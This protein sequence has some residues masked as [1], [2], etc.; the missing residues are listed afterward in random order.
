VK[1]EKI[2]IVNEAII[3]HELVSFVC[4]ISIFYLSPSVT[5]EEFVFK[6]IFAVD[7]L[8]RDPLE[9]FVEQISDLFPLFGTH[10]VLW[11]YLLEVLLRD[12]IQLMHQIDSVLA[13]LAAHSTELVLS[14]ESQNCHLFN[15]L[16][17]LGFPR[18]KGS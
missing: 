8:R 14:G 5:L 13:H 11:Q 6:C 9:E 2:V 3:S 16:A 7:S 12:I 1:E 17:A 10:M 15:E 18:E 4:L